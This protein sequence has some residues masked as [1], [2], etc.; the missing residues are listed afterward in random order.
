MIQRANRQIV[1]A[2]YVK[3][4]FSAKLLPA[5]ENEQNYSISRGNPEHKLSKCHMDATNTR[6]SS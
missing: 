5:F 6:F 2:K 4:P 1:V 3:N